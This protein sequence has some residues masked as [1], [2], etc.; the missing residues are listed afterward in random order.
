MIIK[1]GA[2]EI[3]DEKITLSLQSEQG[4]AKVLPLSKIRTHAIIS[5]FQAGH[6]LIEKKADGTVKCAFL[7]AL[8]ATDAILLQN[9]TYLKLDLTNLVAGSTYEVFGLEYASASR[10]Y[11]EFNNE[12]ITGND[13]QTKTFTPQFGAK[14]LILSNNGSLSS[15]RLSYAGANE[16]TYTPQE[17][18]AIMRSSNDIS[19]APDKL[20]EGDTVNQAIL[21]GGTEFWALSLVGVSKF[22]VTTTGADDLSVMQIVVKSY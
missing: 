10:F 18:D 11:N 12:I 3:V 8:S 21:G 4:S 17:L 19:F 6:Q 5:Q 15:V 13:S 16:V 14:S 2:A 7:L 9:N 1:N 20:I 22:E